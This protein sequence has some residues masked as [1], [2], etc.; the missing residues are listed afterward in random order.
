MA[1]G[2]L[3]KAAGALAAANLVAHVVFLSLFGWRVLTS[4]PIGKVTA[5]VCAAIALAGLASG[6]LGW[7]LVRHGGRTKLRTFGL[8]GIALSTTLAGVLL[9]VASWTG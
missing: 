1:G 9:F 3:Q 4:G 2:P 5:I 8:W 6:G 7:A